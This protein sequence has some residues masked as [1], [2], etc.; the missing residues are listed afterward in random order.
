MRDIP[1][2]HSDVFSTTA[3]LIRHRAG[4]KGRAELMIAMIDY[5]GRAA[6]KIRGI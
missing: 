2:S 5:C 4:D 3:I 1:P 6:W